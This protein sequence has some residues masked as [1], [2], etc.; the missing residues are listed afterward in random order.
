MNWTIK[1]ENVSCL[2]QFQLK[3]LQELK[4]TMFTFGI[5]S[6][7]SHL[8]SKKIQNSNKYS[9]DEK[10]NKLLQIQNCLILHWFL[11]PPDLIAV[12]PVWDMLK[13][14]LNSLKPYTTNTTHLWTSLESVLI[15]VQQFLKFVDSIPNRVT[16][17]IQTKCRIRIRC[18][19]PRPART[20]YF[21]SEVVIDSDW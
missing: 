12:Q 13:N 14:L 2:L 11:H 7:I 21:K 1:I 17:V 5:N 19:Q 3:S 20:R 18:L 4:Y 16:T 8:W 9:Y 15:N 10:N 6:G